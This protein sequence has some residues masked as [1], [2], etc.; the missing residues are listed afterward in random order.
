MIRL[1]LCFAV[2]LSAHVSTMS[3][4]MMTNPTQWYVNNQI[5][6]MRVFHSTVANSMLGRGS[7]RA[8][9]GTTKAAAPEPDVTAFR[10]RS[11]SALPTTLSAN[12]SGISRT[13]AE[14]RQLF[15]SYIALYKATASK[16]GFPANDLAYAFEYFV[17]NNYQIFHDLVDVPYEKDPRA[18]R[19]KTG[20]DRIAIMAEKKTL[21]VSLMQE[22]T[23]YN[24]FRER[25][26]GNADIRRMTDAQKQE[27]A[28]LM[29]TMLGINFAAY[30]KGI[31]SG[32]EAELATAREMARQGLE[33]LLGV[34]IS[35]IRI[36]TAGLEL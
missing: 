21:Q 29:A 1:A 31:D 13:S 24:Q 9:T 33:K 35:R 20:F 2:S 30:N 8:G 22:R 11:P 5:Y 7:A 4:Q 19:G 3:A 28:E 18:K 17:V 16:D 34:P 36:T 23:I 14:A 32:N 25:L 15:E 26:A 12:S 6:S 27:S 10:E